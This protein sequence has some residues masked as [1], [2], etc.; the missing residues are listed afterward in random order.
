MQE[1]A[2]VGLIGAATDIFQPPLKTA[3]HAVVVGGPTAMFVAADCLFEPTHTGQINEYSP[4]MNP[5]QTRGSPVKF[6][7]PNREALVRIG[8]Q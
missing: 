6:I 2:G 3:H 7:S 1:R 4:A 8:S 5:A